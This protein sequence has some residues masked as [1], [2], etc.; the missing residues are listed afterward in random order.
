MNI[1]LHNLAVAQTAHF[2]VTELD[3]RFAPPRPSTG[4]YSWTSVELRQALNDLT[5]KDITEMV[6]K[7]VVVPE[8]R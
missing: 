4:L 3:T 5:D 6:A 7:S 8:R 1:R 2:A